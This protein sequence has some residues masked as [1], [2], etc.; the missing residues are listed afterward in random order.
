VLHGMKC[1][2]PVVVGDR[3]TIGTMRPSM[4]ACSR[5]MCW[6]ALARSSLKRRAHRRGINH[7]RWSCHT[8]AYDD[9]AA[10]PGRRRSRQ[11][12]P[13]AR[14][15]RPGDDPWL[16]GGNYLGYT[17]TYLAEAAESAG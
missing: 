9:S 10:K 7:R 15:R 5:M 6:L 13:L 16:C 4:A 12:A 8:G 11:S 1:L 17:K 14:R 3:V 2:Y